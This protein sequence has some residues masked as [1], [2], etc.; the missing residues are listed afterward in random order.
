MKIDD[1]CLIFVRYPFINLNCFSYFWKCSIRYFVDS[2][3][4]FVTWWVDAWSWLQNAL[5]SVLQDSIRWIG[6]YV[7]LKYWILFL[8]LLL[9]IFFKLLI[10][11]QIKL[12]PKIIITVMCA[13]ILLLLLDINVSTGLRHMY[14]DNVWLLVFATII[15]HF[16]IFDKE[17]NDIS[18]DERWYYYN[19]QEEIIM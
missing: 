17:I 4:S 16:Y 19:Q 11:F 9:S 12:M 15:K 5:H 18:G 1:R 3:R 6:W 2:P 14:F 7:R 10:V 8:F 13:T